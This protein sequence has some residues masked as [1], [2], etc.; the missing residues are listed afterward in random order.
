M[1]ENYCQ[2]TEPA[3]IMKALRDLIARSP[4]IPDPFDISGCMMEITDELLVRHFE[5]GCVMPKLLG[6]FYHITLYQ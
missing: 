1:C 5:R 6:M 4:S 2:V 3:I